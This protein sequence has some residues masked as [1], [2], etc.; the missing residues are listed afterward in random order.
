[1]V[2]TVPIRDPN[3]LIKTA[4]KMVSNATQWAENA[5]ANALLM[6]GTAQVKKITLAFNFYAYIPL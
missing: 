6:K 5:K 3:L 1:M 2:A 4:E